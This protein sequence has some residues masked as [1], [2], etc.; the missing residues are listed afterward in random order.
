[1]GLIIIGLDFTMKSITKPITKLT[2][3]QVPPGALELATYVYFV[4]VYFLLP[5]QQLLLASLIFLYGLPAGTL[6]GK[7][8]N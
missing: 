5:S 8:K 1:M 6:M 3:K 2:T 4:L 7:G